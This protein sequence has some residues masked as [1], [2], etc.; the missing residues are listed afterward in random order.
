MKKGGKKINLTL[1]FSARVLYSAIAILIFL[2]IIIFTVK[3]SQKIE[4]ILLILLLIHIAGI[5][6][7]YT[8]NWFDLIFHFVWGFFLAQIILIY[9]KSDKKTRLSMLLT[10][11]FAVSLATLFGVLWEFFEFFWD[12]SF[13]V[14]SIYPRAQVSLADTMVDLILDVL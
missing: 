9:L 10:T 8:T 13:A 4:L 7:L 5:L 12:S 2:I 6:W 14:N 11:F 1:V 3:L